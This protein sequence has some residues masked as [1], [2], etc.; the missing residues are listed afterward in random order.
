[1]RKLMKIVFL[2]IMI[3]IHCIVLSN[4]KFAHN[5][6]RCVPCIVFIIVI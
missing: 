1:M 2:I 5:V 6:C 3:G 4:T